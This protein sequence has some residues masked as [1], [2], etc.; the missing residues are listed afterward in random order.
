MIALLGLFVPMIREQ[1][2]MMYE[3]E[4]PFVVDDSK[5]TETF[6]TDPTPLDEAI[7]ETVAWYRQHHTAADV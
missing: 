7:R 5:F 4:E 1:K 3:F 2:E 6:D